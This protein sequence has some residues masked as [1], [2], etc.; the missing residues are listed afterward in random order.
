MESEADKSGPRGCEEEV[1]W[2]QNSRNARSFLASSHRAPP[3]GPGPLG[4]DPH[5]QLHPGCLWLRGGASY[6][7]DPGLSACNGW[8]VTSSKMP[9]N[10]SRDGNLNSALWFDLNRL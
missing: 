9:V 2:G 3:T 1:L 10:N 4:G 8:C 6:F 7:P 5:P